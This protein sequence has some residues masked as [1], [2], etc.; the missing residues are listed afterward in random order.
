MEYKD[1]NDIEEHYHSW[2]E[3][4]SKVLTEII[5]CFPAVEVNVFDSKNLSLERSLSFNTY[6]IGIHAL[7]PT[8]QE[9]GELIIRFIRA[10]KDFSSPFKIVE[11]ARD[12]EKLKED[13]NQLSKDIF[14][15]YK[16]R[17]TLGLTSAPYGYVRS[18]DFETKESEK[19]KES[20]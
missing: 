1:E 19:G 6:E 5:S 4:D 10:D 17:K 11:E 3:G 9:K 20:S 16:N 8:F 18:G 13:F 12:I 7:I 15:A 2:Y 14:Q